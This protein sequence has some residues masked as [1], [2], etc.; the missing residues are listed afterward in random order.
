[1]VQ[2]QGKGEERG[3]NL[4]VASPFFIIRFAV[5]VSVSGPISPELRMLLTLL[6][7]NDC[8]CRWTGESMLKGKVRW[9]VE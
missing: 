3:R 6:N 5:K 7:A 2:G 9:L 8:T 1:M 4:G